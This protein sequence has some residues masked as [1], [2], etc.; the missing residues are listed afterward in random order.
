MTSELV[1]DAEP[2]LAYFWD[3]E[4]SDDVDEKLQKVENGELN[5]YISYVTCSEV[6]YVVRRKQDEETAD[7]Y[8]KSIMAELDCLDVEN[9][10]S[11]AAYFKYEYNTSLGDAFTLGTAS[12]VERFRKDSV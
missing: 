11:K 9:V 6:H 8:L 1:F 7:A 5:G 12:E 2:L 3:E 10:W 4:G